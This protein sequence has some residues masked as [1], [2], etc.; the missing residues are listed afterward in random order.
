M[1]QKQEFEVVYNN[2]V[3]E[4]IEKERE[5][6][7]YYKLPEKDIEDI[8]EYAKS[9][10]KRHIVII[11]IGGSSL[12]TYAIY[13]FLKAKYKFEKE[14]HFLESTDPIVLNDKISSIDLEDAIFMVISKS[15]TTIETISIFKYISSLIELKEGNVVFITDS[16]SKL[17]KYAKSK[18]YKI[19]NIESSVGGRFSVLSAVGLLP[20]AVI[21]VDID[22]LQNGA[23]EIKDS[24]FSKKESSIKN[25]L[26]KKATFYSKNMSKYNIN[27][28]FSYSE[29]FRGFN[30]WYI[31]LWGES[32]GKRQLHSQLNVGLTPIGLI[33]PTDQ[34]SFL[35][36]IVDG[37]RDKSVTFI[38][39][40]DF[41]ESLEI[42]DVSIDGIEELDTING[43]KFSELINLQAD[44]IIESLKGL[45]DIPLDII[46]IEKVDESSIGKLIYYY[47]LLTSLVAKMLDINAYDQPGVED[48]KKILKDKLK[49]R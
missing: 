27:C 14:L 13:Q 16:G 31:Q 37:K 12:G 5:E 21:G 34:H 2:L 10:K 47:E 8:K 11:G 6:V 38:K 9:V 30:S 20:L 28:I 42:P 23:K 18:K 15:G 22:A 17:E 49:S 46:E 3:Y 41:G 24:F 43:M 1:V 33:G 39:I 35:Q 45:K 7:G 19:F 48:G 44:S 40:K 32:L 26:L 29:L 25:D 36:L 4:M